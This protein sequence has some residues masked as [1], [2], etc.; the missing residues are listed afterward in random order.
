M[1]CNHQLVETH[2]F[3][4][5]D[6]TL[7]PNL[8]RA[9][10]HAVDH[11]DECKLMYQ[12]AS[13]LQHFQSSWKDQTVPKWHRTE[14]AVA[15]RSNNNWGWLNGLSLATSTLALLMVLFRVEMIS[16][17]A[18]FSIGFGGKASQIAMNEQIDEK[19]QQMALQQVEYLDNRFEE[20]RLQTISDN[21]VMVKAL[22]QHNRQERRHDMNTLMAS[23]LQQR[24][25]DQN[26]IGLKVDSIVEN[27]I[28]Q[29]KTINDLLKVS[30]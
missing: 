1:S 22:L 21:E 29:S 20:N 24:D 18:G 10:E 19:I 25:I 8:S 27:Q 7:S 15:K 13:E 26:Q 4:Y 9:F 12:N 2:L 11:C 3:E 28:E 30:N 16:T 14:F 23:W 17:D 6:S 5:L